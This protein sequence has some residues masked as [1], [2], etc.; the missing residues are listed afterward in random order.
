MRHALQKVAKAARH[1]GTRAY[2]A[3]RHLAR[4]IDSAVATSARVYGGLIQPVLRS[5]GY[6]TKEL[7]R[8]LL[9]T[10]SLYNDL[11]D[12][13]TKGH[14]VVEGVAANL[15]GGDFKYAV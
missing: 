12:H 5:Q 15:R 6:D 7:D 10:H 1:H 3:A 8:N 13:V 4:G 9:K 14:R 11:K 2:V